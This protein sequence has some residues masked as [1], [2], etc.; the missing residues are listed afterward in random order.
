[1]IMVA[2]PSYRGLTEWY[3]D[4]GVLMVPII[5]SVARWEKNSNHCSRKQYSL[6]LAYVISIY[7]SRGMTLSK[8]VIEFGDKP[9]FCRGLSF[10]AISRVRALCDLAC[11]SR[12]GMGRF[13]NVG[14]LDKVAEDIRRPQSL[15]FHDVV[16]P[17][18]LGFSFND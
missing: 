18:A 4:D 6:R 3:N 7:K 2:I 1:M 16:N 17:A 11:R 8:A 9:D 12:I 10:V 14:G 15:P 5:P 13:K